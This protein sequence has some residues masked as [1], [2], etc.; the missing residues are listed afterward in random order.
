[1]PA[2]D[3]LLIRVQSA[4]NGWR[5][6]EARLRDLQSVHWFQPGLAPHPL[7]HGYISC[8]HILAGEIPHDCDGTAASHRVLVC[9][10]KK[11]NIPAAFA[12]LARRADQASAIPSHPRLFLSNSGVDLM[13]TMN[14]P[15]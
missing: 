2:H 6:A 5:S 9:V 1:M 11:H 15:R 4:W 3:D 13:Q 7:V 14:R 10:L 8:A 12:E